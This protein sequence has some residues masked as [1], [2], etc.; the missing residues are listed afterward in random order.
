MWKAPGMKSNQGIL[1]NAKAGGQSFLFQTK[2]AGVQLL[3][4]C[5]IAAPRGSL[6]EQQELPTDSSPQELTMSARPLPAAAN[7]TR[8]QRLHRFLLSWVFLAQCQISFSL[9]AKL[10]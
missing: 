4:G 2:A 5:D 1:H 6:E 7:Q 10:I 8:E 9:G 3:L